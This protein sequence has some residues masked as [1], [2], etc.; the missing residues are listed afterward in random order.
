MEPLSRVGFWF[1]PGR[2]RGTPPAIGL[3]H[4][5]AHA[6]GDMVSA[7]GNDALHKMTAHAGDYHNMEE[8]RVITM[9][10]H[11]VARDLGYPI[12]ENHGGD[13]YRVKTPFSTDD[14]VKKKAA[15]AVPMNKL[16][17][18]LDKQNK[19]G[20]IPF[21]RGGELKTFEGKQKTRKSGGRKGGPSRAKSPKKK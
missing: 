9:V 3:I 5:L 21:F 7:K 13:Y 19:A 2:L 16:G 20:N 6:E 10:E 18:F 17:S 15:K 1:D 11:K 8:R 14:V 12:R 4:E